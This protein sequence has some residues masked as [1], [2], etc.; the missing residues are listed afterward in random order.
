VGGVVLLGLIIALGLC[1]LRRRLNR[2][3]YFPNIERNENAVEEAVAAIALPLCGSTPS[4]V[5]LTGVEKLYLICETPKGSVY[6]GAL[7]PSFDVVLKSI[8]NISREQLDA[9]VLEAAVVKT[10]VHPNIVLFYG[11]FQDPTENALYCV[12]EFVPLRLDALLTDTNPVVR[13]SLTVAVLLK[14]GCD[15][16]IALAALEER[17]IVHRHLSPHNIL[18]TNIENGYVIKLDDIL[19]RYDQNLNENIDNEQISPMKYC[20][21]ETVSNNELTTKSNVFTF[22]VILW[23]ILSFGQVPYSNINNNEIYD[24]LMAGNRLPFP[25]NNDVISEVFSECWQISPQQRPSFKT[26]AGKIENCLSSLNQPTNTHQGNAS[27]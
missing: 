18:V 19:S 16:A 21:P 12:S 20:A 17:N 13:D 3:Q 7:P 26:I 5:Y 15:L 4:P 2:P 27:S 23:Q 6:R 22:G 25:I 8:P 24:W 14:I 10:L 1:C 9:L 11:L